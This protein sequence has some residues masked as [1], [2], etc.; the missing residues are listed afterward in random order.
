[1]IWVSEVCLFILFLNKILLTFERTFDFRAWQNCSAYRFDRCSPEKDWF[2]ERLKG[3][4]GEIS[5]NR[6]GESSI[7][8]LSLQ[9]FV[10][11]L[12]HNF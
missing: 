12:A 9:C 11:F 5:S 3:D 4:K 6:R 2:Q 7:V 1:M 10:L 8:Y